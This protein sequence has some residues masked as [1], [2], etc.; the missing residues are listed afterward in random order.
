MVNDPW[1]EKGR[2]EGVQWF[3]FRS[4]KVVLKVVDNYRQVK[5][6]LMFWIVFTNNALYM[7]AYDNLLLFYLTFVSLN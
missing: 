5:E 3:A 2:V 6:V 7:N 1:R 4:S